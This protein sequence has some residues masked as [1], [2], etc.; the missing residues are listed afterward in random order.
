MQRGHIIPK[1][2]LVLR[3]LNCAVPISMTLIAIKFSIV[4]KVKLKLFGISHCFLENV[5]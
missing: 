2:H 5:Y 4:N 3:T 1:G